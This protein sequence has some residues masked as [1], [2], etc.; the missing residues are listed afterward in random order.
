M[1]AALLT[2]P[3]A[4]LKI[5]RRESRMY[6]AETILPVR[7]NQ[8]YFIIEEPAGQIITARIMQDVPLAMAARFAKAAK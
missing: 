8:C 2:F 6:L 5:E 7:L 3:S 1:L 4:R